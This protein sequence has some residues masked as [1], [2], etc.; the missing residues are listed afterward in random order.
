MK[1]VVNFVCATLN[2]SEINLDKIK[3]SSQK[4]ILAYGTKQNNLC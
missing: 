4:D 3:K 2:Q 1:A